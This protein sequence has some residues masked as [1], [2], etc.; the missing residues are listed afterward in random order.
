L[1]YSGV[2]AKLGARGRRWEVPRNIIGIVIAVI[3]IIVVIYL[4]LRIV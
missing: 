2:G 3:V 1:R 4:I